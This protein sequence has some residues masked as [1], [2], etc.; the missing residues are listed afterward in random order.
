[1]GNWGIAFTGL[2]TWLLMSLTY[3][4]T[5]RFYKCPVWLVFCLS[6]YAHSLYSHDFRLSFTSLARTRGCKDWTL[7]IQDKAFM[8]VF[9]AGSPSHPLSPTP[10]KMCPLQDVPNAQCP[11]TADAPLG[12]TPRPHCLPNAQCPMPPYLCRVWAI[13]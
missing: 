13:A 6:A 1:M 5:I 10:C 9:L 4:P 3:L 7:C 8:D 2:L 11:M 12:E